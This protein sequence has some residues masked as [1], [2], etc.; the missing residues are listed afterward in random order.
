MSMSI[1]LSLSESAR[2][3]GV[4]Q[5]TLRRAIADEQIPYLMVQGRYKLQFADLVYW[6]NQSTRMIQKR[7]TSGIGQYVSQWDELAVNTNRTQSAT[8]A[9]P[10]TRHFAKSSTRKQKLSETTNTLP[11]SNN[12]IPTNTPKEQTLNW[13]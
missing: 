7:D 2:L 13:D 8:T 9:Q 3:F 11:R 4:S 5:R 12:T 10:P 6:S 1:L